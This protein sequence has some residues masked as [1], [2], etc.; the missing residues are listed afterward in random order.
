MNVWRAF[1]HVLSACVKSAVHSRVRAGR[2]ELTSSTRATRI[3]LD[4]CMAL[5]SSV[6]TPSPIDWQMALPAK[7]RMTSARLTAALLQHMMLEISN[8]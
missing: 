6:P 7:P 1:A 8:R 3:M 5:Y 2:S 4:A